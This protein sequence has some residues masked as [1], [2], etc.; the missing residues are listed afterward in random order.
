MGLF[1]VLVLMTKLALKREEVEEE[2]LE[3]NFGLF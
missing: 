1:L 2:I 3:K